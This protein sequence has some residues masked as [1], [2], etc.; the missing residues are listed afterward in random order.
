[1]D[2]EQFGVQRT[3]NPCASCHARSVVARVELVFEFFQLSC[4]GISD[5]GKILDVPVV[6]V[7]VGFEEPNSL[8]QVAVYSIAHASAGPALLLVVAVYVLGV[9]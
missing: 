2:S 9:L 8:L 6:L 7:D 3:V 1:M 4:F 5:F